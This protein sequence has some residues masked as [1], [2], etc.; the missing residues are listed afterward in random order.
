MS[1]VYEFVNCAAV[2][3]RQFRPDQIEGISALSEYASAIASKAGLS[4]ALGQAE[5]GVKKRLRCSQAVCANSCDGDP[6]WLCTGSYSAQLVGRVERNRRGLGR[7]DCGNRRLRRTRF[8]GDTR[9]RRAG[10]RYCLVHS[11]GVRSL[12]RRDA[13]ALFRGDTRSFY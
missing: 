3:L 6:A 5:A 8:C 10:A 4:H 2:D 11:Q 7:A 1:A 9:I 12:C 13:G